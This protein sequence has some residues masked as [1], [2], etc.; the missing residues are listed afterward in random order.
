VVQLYAADSVAS[1]TWPITQPIGFARVRL[2]PSASAEV[3]FSVHTDRLS[4]A[5]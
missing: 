3:S 1:L 2:A 4:F 5:G